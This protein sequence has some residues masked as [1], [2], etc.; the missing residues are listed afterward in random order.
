MKN[1]LRIAAGPAS[2]LLA[3][4]FLSMSTPASAG[5]YCHTDTSGMRGCGYATMEQ[6]EAAASG[7][8]GA[9]CYR[10]PFLAEA[11]NPKNA[12]AYQPTSKRAVHHAKPVNAQ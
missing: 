5:E 2:A 8:G 3:V 6:C 1:V 7:K 12:L 9:G 11:S 10:D 4:A